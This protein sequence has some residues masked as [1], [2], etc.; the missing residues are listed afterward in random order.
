MELA[1]GA[2]QDA[3]MEAA[4]AQGNISKWIG[5]LADVKK[6]IY[7]PGKILNIVAPPPKQ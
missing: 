5:D 1:V 3:A 7:V 2:A 6:V 4:M